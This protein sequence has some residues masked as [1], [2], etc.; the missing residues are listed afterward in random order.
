M[1]GGRRRLVGRPRRTRGFRDGRFCPPPPGRM[2]RAPPEIRRR[3]CDE[4]DRRPGDQRISDGRPLNADDLLRRREDRY[5]LARSLL[6]RCDRWRASLGRQAAA[7]IAANLGLLLILVVLLNVA[8]GGNSLGGLAGAGFRLW[9][10]GNSLLVLAAAIVAA[11]ALRDHARARP[12]G[13]QRPP[14][15]A[16]FD[17]EETAEAF[18]TPAALDA[19]FR[20]ALDE[21]MM[22]H[23]F[24]ALWRATQSAHRRRRI[25]RWALRFLLLAMAVTVGSFILALLCA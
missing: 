24:A 2:V 19:A 20:S 7:L 11:W 21:E 9:L 12:G 6:A 13:A 10:A 5:A 17:L 15:A 25:L 22:R 23:A 3:L 18:A 16:F 1:T 8:V 4:L 14:A